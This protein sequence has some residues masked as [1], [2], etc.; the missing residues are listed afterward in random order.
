MLFAII[1]HI[2]AF[3]AIAV[4]FSFREKPASTVTEIQV[5]EAVAIDEK[6]IKAEQDKRQQEELRKQQAEQEK[7]RKAQEA[8]ELKEKQAREEKQRIAAEKERKARLEKEKKEKAL[9]EARQKKQQE[10]MAKR[11]EQEKQAHEAEAQRRREAEAQKQKEAAAR[12]ADSEIK[13]HVTLI[14]VAVQNN[15]LI[16]PSYQK[17][18]SCVVAVRMIP[19]GEVVSARIVKSSGDPAF[20]RSVEQAVQKASPLPVPSIESGLFD[21]FRELNLIFDPSKFR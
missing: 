3:L 10:E 20:D 4:S 6:K 19:G 17:G 14:T 1:V 15:W 13:R 5:M 11:L 8:K 9:K 18:M 21:Q 7:I 16:P 12:Q 2:M